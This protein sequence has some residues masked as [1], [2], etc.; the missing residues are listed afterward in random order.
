MFPYVRDQPTAAATSTATS[1]RSAAPQQAVNSLRSAKPSWH[2]AP[3]RN[4]AGDQNRQRIIV[5]IAGGMTYS[6]MRTAYQISSSMNKDV[7]IGRLNFS[8]YWLEG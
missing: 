3:S 1:L 4:A 7:F 5:F 8:V 2:R 6:E